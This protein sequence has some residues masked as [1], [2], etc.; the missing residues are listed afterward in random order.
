MANIGI[1]LGPRE[2][3]V[4][5]Y[6]LLLLT[7]Q[8]IPSY[9][10]NALLMPCLSFAPVTQQ[11]DVPFDSKAS[12]VSLGFQPRG[13]TMGPLVAEFSLQVAFVCEARKQVGIDPFLRSLPKSSKVLRRRLLNGGSVIPSLVHVTE[14]TS[15]ETPDFLRTVYS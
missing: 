10:V 11:S 6:T 4:I 1:N 12:R 5:G 3:W 9:S 14:V 15:H 13:K 2:G 7:K 8:P